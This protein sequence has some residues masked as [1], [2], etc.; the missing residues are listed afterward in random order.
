MDVIDTLSPT[1][2]ARESLEKKV[3]AIKALVQLVESSEPVGKTPLI[4]DAA[5]WVH[6]AFYTYRSAMAD[7]DPA[8]P[9]LA[10]IEHDFIAAMVA[11]NFD[12]QRRQLRRA[13]VAIL[14][15]PKAPR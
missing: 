15:F 9:R 11:L 12:D 4:R 3:S 1:A 6:T 8:L 5:A 2:L 14:A 10:R 7:N 13:Q